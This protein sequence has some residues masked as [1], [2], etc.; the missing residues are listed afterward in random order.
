MLRTTKE[1]VELFSWAGFILVIVATMIGCILLSGTLAAAIFHTVALTAGTPPGWIKGGALAQVLVFHSDMGKNF[2][3][4]IVAWT[5]CFFLTMVISLMTKRTKTDQ[6]LTGLVYSL[7]PKP[8]SEGEPWY[9]Q[10]VT[11]GILVLIATVALNIIF[12]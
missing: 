1:K 3:M 6:E 4:A 12:R 8:K 11:L 5:T 9:M 2:W 10:P 7:T